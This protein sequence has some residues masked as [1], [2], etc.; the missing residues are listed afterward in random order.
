MANDRLR[1][2]MA[3]AHIDIELIVQ[4]TGVDPK[5]VKRWLAGR[6]PHPKYRWTLASLLN[7]REDY[8]WPEA[9][10]AITATNQTLE[11]MAAYSHRADVPLS[12]WWQHF[13]HAQRHIDLLAFAMLFLPEQHP[14]LADLLKAKSEAACKIRICV[15]DPASI[16]VKK[17]DEEEQ[18]GGTLPARIRTTLRHF[19]DL[20]PC[21]GIEIRYHTIPMYNSV[22]RFDDE[23][24]VTPHLYGL[25][26]SRAPLLH[27][28]RLGPD[29]IFANFAAHFEAVWATTTSVQV[30][31]FKIEKL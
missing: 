2:A 25:H 9:V 4:K 28:R 19:R 24:F 1:S 7:E 23:M 22:F 11:I 5:T 31:D 3:S 15:A 12:A 30:N 14:G 6:A 10:E 17:R 21:P 13:L 8:L 26:G 27:I 20:A 18:L 16:E 29:G